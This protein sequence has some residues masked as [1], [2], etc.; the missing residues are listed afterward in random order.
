MH[1]HNANS[2]KVPTRYPHTGM[3]Y[4]LIQHMYSYTMLLSSEPVLAR[5]VSCHFPAGLSFSPNYYCD[6]VHLLVTTN[7]PTKFDDRRPMR[8]INIDL[9]KKL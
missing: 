2:S 1:S 8:S 4:A 5:A 6:R 3:K 9:W 7:L